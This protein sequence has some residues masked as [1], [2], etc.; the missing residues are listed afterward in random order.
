MREHGSGYCVRHWDD[1]SRSDCIQYLVVESLL[2][3]S[4]LR[5]WKDTPRSE[6]A[7]NIVGGVLCCF[8]Y[9]VLGVYIHLLLKG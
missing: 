3:F 8:L 2:P 5:H 6:R 1:Y 4:W 7:G 9:L